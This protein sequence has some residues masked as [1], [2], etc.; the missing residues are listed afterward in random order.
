VLETRELHRI[1]GSEPI[2]AD[3]R[4]V[5]ATNRDPHEAVAA[6]RLRE[7]LLYRLMVFPIQ[8][9]PLREREG[10]VEQIAKQLLGQ[11][12]Q[13]AG[14]QKRFSQEA[15]DLLAA[16]AWPGNVRELRNCVERAFI[17]ATDQ[18]G[19]EALPFTA[20][21]PASGPA[22]DGVWLPLGASIADAERDLIRIT[23]EHHDGDRTRTA[24][25]LGISVR[26]LYNRLKEYGWT[27]RSAG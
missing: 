2:A 6:G 22:R 24:Q 18:I 14:T 13:Q 11:L 25:A 27:Q 20:P 7:D 1:G 3:V 15:L 12:N 17:L 16:Q 21:A 5:A 4:V 23:L 19:R 8:V 9:P 26:T 10:D